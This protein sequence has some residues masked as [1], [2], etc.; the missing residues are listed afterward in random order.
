MHQRPRVIV[1]I[2]MS[3][4]GMIAGRSGRRVNISSEDDW[5]RVY[6]L[7]STVDAVVIGANTVIHDNPKLTTG[8]ETTSN[9]GS[10]ARII[11]DAN[12]RVPRNA[13]VF[14]GSA[15]TIVFTT[16][17]GEKISGA[18]VEGR[19][20]NELSISELLYEIHSMGFHRILVEGGK[21]VIGEFVSSGNVDEFFLYIG[22]TVIESGGLSLFDVETEVSNIIKEVMPMKSGI[23]ISLNPYLLRETWKISPRVF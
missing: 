3:L 12:L 20:A 2:A 21:T 13:T 22:N 9:R 15:R 6:K 23:L 14:D 10:P 19:N 1:N 17:K 16:K 18:E 7:R 5:K 11:L 4:N 8:P